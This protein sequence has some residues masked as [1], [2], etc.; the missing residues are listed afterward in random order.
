MLEFVP[1]TEGCFVLGREGDEGLVVFA[2]LTD[3]KCKS[4]CGV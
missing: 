2:E 3:A 1:A 4:L